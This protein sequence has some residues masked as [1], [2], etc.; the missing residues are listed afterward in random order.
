MSKSTTPYGSWRS[1][2]SIDFAAGGFN[3]PGQIAVS[4]GVIYWSESRPKEGG[5][6]AVMR[7][8]GNHRR[9]AEEATPPE[10]NCRTRVHE[11][12]GG[13]YLADGTRLYASNFVD[14]RLY[15][16]EPGADPVPIT[17]EPEQPAGLRYADGRLTPDGKRILCVRETHDADGTVTNELVSIDL[18][19]G[20]PGAAPEHG[21]QP[22]AQADVRPIATGRDFYA[23]PRLDPD[24]R[25]L[26]W[27]EWDHPAMPW[28]GTELW[29]AELNDAGE[30]EQPRRL[31]GGPEESIFQ[32]EWSPDGVLH[33]VSDRSG[34]WNLYR[35]TGDTA[36]PLAPR[37]AEFGSPM[38]IFGLSRYCFVPDGRLLC[39]YSEQLIDKLGLVSA[40]GLEPLETEF[41]AFRPV[42]LH[43]DAA[44]NRA[45]FVASNAERPSSVYALE[46]DSGELTALSVPPA[47]MPHPDYVS[48]GEPITF[49]TSGGQS[50]H[51]IYYRPANREHQGP[52]DRLPPLLVVSHGGPTSNTNLEFGKELLIFTSRGFAVV[53]VNY[54]GS[55][56]YGR[57]YRQL[58]NGQ[59]GVADVEDCIAAARHLVEK[60]EVD[61]KM[62]VIRGGSAGG[63]TTLCALVFHDF[64]TAGASYYGVADIEALANLTHKFEARY[65]DSMI[66]PYPEQAE[67]YRK[68]SP[69]HFVDQLSCPVVIL[70]G[71][72]DQVVPQAQAERMV[73]AL[74]AK[75]L[76][77][78]YLLFPDEAHGFRKSENVR[79]ALEAELY[80]YSRLFGFELA[81]PVTPITVHNLE[82]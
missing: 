8:T 26:A 6:I 23:F 41:T 2:I 7:L 44:T 50:A 80:F 47:H 22:G 16:C 36:Q 77:Y 55:T 63:Y 64:F 24:G 58:L 37:S 45:V 17:P 25:Q 42:S 29:V 40:A 38:W 59:W 51:A 14:Q 78:A 3:R 28:D 75:G 20:E 49:P 43:F 19:G 48:R 33:F 71:G 68:R 54:R 69:V 10:F 76:P 32:P 35:W 9:P 15:R 56:G 82:D 34:W 39:I 67:L 21:V 5:R 11:Y 30:L 31:A 60:D 81:D 57:Q 52:A 13:A 74:E 79:R 72:E 18:D 65:L 62:L 53:D 70:Q 27:I 12:G 61:P 46:L 1:P 4:D 73:E 66:G